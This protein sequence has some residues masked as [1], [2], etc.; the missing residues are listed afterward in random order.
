MGQKPLLAVMISVNKTTLSNVALKDIQINEAPHQAE[1]TEQSEQAE[2][3]GGFKSISQEDFSYLPSE[4]R[5]GLLEHWSK[6]MDVS[7]VKAAWPMCPITC[8]DYFNDC[9][10]QNKVFESLA[11]CADAPEIQ[12]AFDHFKATEKKILEDKEEQVV[13]SMLQNATNL[14]QLS[15]SGG[16][17]GVNSTGAGRKYK[18]DF[19]RAICLALRSPQA[20]VLKQQTAL[21]LI[22]LS[23]HLKGQLEVLFKKEDVTEKMSVLSEVLSSGNKELLHACLSKEP[24]L[25]M[26]LLGDTKNTAISMAGALRSKDSTKQFKAWLYVKPALQWA[27]EHKPE[28]ISQIHDNNLMALL[29]SP[30]VEIREDLLKIMPQHVNASLKSHIAADYYSGTGLWLKACKTKEESCMTFILKHL[31]IK[32]VMDQKSPTNPTLATKTFD[33]GGLPALKVLLE[34]A[35]KQDPQLVEAIL[36]QTCWVWENDRHRKK[37]DM[38]AYCVIHGHLESCQYILETVPHVDRAYA[39]AAVEYLRKK[40]IQAAGTALAVWENLI[41]SDLSRSATVAS[42]NK[43]N[44]QDASS[45]NGSPSEHLACVMSDEPSKTAASSRKRL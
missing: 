3:G 17:V 32:E 45:E 1:Q 29:I 13:K 31:D 42:K 18:I 15:V 21:K 14:A 11:R 34:H 39:K 38:L 6:E 27:I 10:P 8:S 36:S 25:F 35:K 2:Q 40:G 7:Q 4:L 12:R 28:L 41:L 44:A 33:D 16:G 20:D 43:T 37:G 30:C 26:G 19:G 24:S 23:D 9:I 22:E 5:L